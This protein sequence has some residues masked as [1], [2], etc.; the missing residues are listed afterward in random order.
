[1]AGKLS[2]HVLTELLGRLELL[3]DLHTAVTKRLLGLLGRGGLRQGNF[4]VEI[5]GSRGEIAWLDSSVLDTY[6]FDVFLV[7]WFFLFLFLFGSQ[8]SANVEGLGLNAS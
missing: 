6:H 5:H 3:H 1:M 8:A 2:L 4:G 7:I